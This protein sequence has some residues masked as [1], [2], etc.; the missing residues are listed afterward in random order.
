MSG[1]TKK[2][3]RVWSLAMS[4]IVVVSS[5]GVKLAH[6]CDQKGNVVMS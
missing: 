4:I 2:N 3:F 6:F 5:G 1:E